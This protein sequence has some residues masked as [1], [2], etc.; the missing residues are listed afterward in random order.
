M[1]AQHLAHRLSCGQLSEALSPQGG[2]FP[3]NLYLS[4]RLFA[5]FSA[6]CTQAI[7]TSKLGQALPLGSVGFGTFNR[8]ERCPRASNFLPC[9]QLLQALPPVVAHQ[10]KKSSS[11][12][13]QRRS[14]LSLYIL[15]SISKTGLGR[16]LASVPSFHRIP[17]KFETIRAALGGALFCVFVP[18][19]I[20]EDATC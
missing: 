18:P 12:S 20:S 9:W 2:G 17:P 5:I 11:W 7:I 13:T 10:K 3:L 4:H 16:A 1:A 14:L 8:S 15:A 19:L 6:D